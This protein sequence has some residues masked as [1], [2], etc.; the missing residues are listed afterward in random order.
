MKSYRLKNHN[1]ADNDTTINASIEILDSKLK[2]NYQVVGDI[3]KYHFPSKTTQQRANNLWLDTCFELFIANR[4]ED[5]YWEINISPSTKWNS[6]HFT[7]YKE[8]MRESN[9]FLTPQIKI[10]KQKNKYELFFETTF[11]RGVLKEKLDINLSVILLDH[12]GKRNFYT[13]NRRN[14]SPD[15]HDRAT[16]AIFEK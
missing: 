8:E 13:I 7:R 6:Y 11:S 4:N 15:F 3:S 12:K 16:F 1:P 10:E 2:L 9:L 14:D 5:S